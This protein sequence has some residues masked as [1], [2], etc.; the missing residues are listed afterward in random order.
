MPFEPE[1]NIANILKKIS[2]EFSDH[3]E[4]SEKQVIVTWDY[5][6][7]NHYSY[8]GKIADN[9]EYNDH[10]VLVD[11][12]A[13]DFNSRE[14]IQEMMFSVSKSISEFANIPENKI[15]IVYSSAHSVFVLDEGNIVEW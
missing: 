3:M 2:S 7:E 14:R 4:I 12:I 10:P 6:K 11:L 9:I 15:F 1:K 8:Q 5:F 13:P